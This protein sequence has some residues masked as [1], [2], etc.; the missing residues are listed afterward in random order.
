MGVLM[1]I[2]DRGRRRQNLASLWDWLAIGVVPI[3]TVFASSANRI[4]FAFIAVGLLMLAPGATWT[5]F[6]NFVLMFL[7]GS[8][9]FVGWAVVQGH[10]SLPQRAALMMLPVTFGVAASRQWKKL[11][12][13]Q[14]MSPQRKN[15]IEV[16]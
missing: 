2:R 16:I 15:Q 9:T 8:I 14:P 5:R 1:R 13:S 12:R 3:M 10:G 7:F 6:A 11:R 4:R